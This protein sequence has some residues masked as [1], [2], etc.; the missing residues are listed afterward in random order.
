MPGLTSR[1]PGLFRPVPFSV[2]TLRS[3]P[4]LTQL[5]GVSAALSA[6]SC[7]GRCWQSHQVP[8]GQSWWCRC[9]H[10]TQ[11]TVF[12]VPLRRV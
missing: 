10:A 2:V 5:N 7:A 8:P 1:A 3:Q 6:A 9:R 4:C 12:I 11:I